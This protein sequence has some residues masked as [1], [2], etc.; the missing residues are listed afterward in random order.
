MKMFSTLRAL[1]V[2]LEAQRGRGS[3][4]PSCGPT[5]TADVPD[6]SCRDDPAAVLIVSADDDVSRDAHAPPSSSARLCDA[7]VALQLLFDKHV[8]EDS[9]SHRRCRAW[10]LT[11]TRDRWT[12]A[13]DGVHYLKGALMMATPRSVCCASRYCCMNAGAGGAR[14]EDASR[15]VRPRRHL[16]QRGHA[17]MRRRR[18]V[19]PRLATHHYRRSPPSSVSLPLRRVLLLESVDDGEYFIL[20][21]LER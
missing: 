5:K 12:S 10:L 8:F 3:C 7:V 2:R 20:R 1:R 17:P 4:C 15:T 6:I 14:A 11:W 16:A 18:A 13:D 9:G 19:G 21:P